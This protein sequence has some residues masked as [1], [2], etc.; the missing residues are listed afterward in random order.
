MR[1]ARGFYAILDRADE[2]LARSLAAHA[3]VLQV[4]LKPSRR[5]IGRSRRF[6]LTV[7]IVATDASRNRSTYTRTVRVR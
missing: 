1:F 4:R 7:Q 6:T 2:A 3:D 5:L